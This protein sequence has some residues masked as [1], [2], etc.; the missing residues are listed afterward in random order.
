MT[1]F[2][3][4]MEQALYGPTGYYSSG[5]AK[6]G[7]AGDYY[8]APDVGQAFGKLLSEYF[9]LWKERLGALDFQV[10]E[11]GAG[12]GRLAA[13]ILSSRP[14][15]YC[16]VEKSPARRTLLKALQAIHPSLTISSNLNALSSLT[17]VLFGNELI[18]AFPVH[19]VRFE[20]GV[21]R[22]LFFEQKGDRKKFFW[23]EPS[24]PQLVAYFQRL[25][26][27]LPDPYETEVNLGMRVWLKEA[28]RALARGI[29]LL[30]DYG[31]PA[32]EYYAPER[33]RGTL[34]A[35]SKHKV[36][37][38]FLD[39]GSMVDLTADVDFTSLALD[40]QE[41][42]LVPLGYLEMGAFLLHIIGNLGA[43]QNAILESIKPSQLKLLVHPEAMGSAFH[44]LILGKGID[45]ERWPIEHNR[46]GRLGLP[47]A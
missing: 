42:G 1:T 9:W 8:T 3:D 35:F 17:G 36:S 19:R 38:D 26:I 4:Y 27:E 43:D 14:F 10:V 22:E 28:A 47:S 7:K 37:A 41:A 21:I 29:V 16:A 20:K 15:A 46:I 5:V 23:G 44:V 34:R 33:S 2:A 6:S 45:P 13:D 25:G 18:D 39:P 11:A 31:R 40:A 32:H 30:I 24:T 12:E